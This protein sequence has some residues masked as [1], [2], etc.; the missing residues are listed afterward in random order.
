MKKR[1]RFLINTLG[2]GGA[3]KVLVDLLNKLDPQKYD[4]SLVI[5]YGGVNREKLHDHIHVRQLVPFR[6]GFLKWL[7]GSLLFKLPDK[8]FCACFLRGTYDAEIA[9]LEGIPT[10]RIAALKTNAA[11]IAFVHQDVFVENIVHLPYGS[12]E[13]CLAAYRSLD[14]VCFVSKQAQI[15]FEKSVGELHNARILHNVVDVE[16][17]LKRS[18]EP[19][20]E[21]FTTTGLKLVTVGR[22]ASPK[23]YQRLLR[24]IHRL[25]KEY[26]MELWI[27]GDGEERAVLERMISKLKLS[28]VRLLGY[29]DNPYALVKQAD[30]FVCSSDYEGYSTAVTEAVLLGVPVLTTDCAGMDEILCDGQYGIIVENS[31]EGMFDGLQCLLCDRNRYYEIKKIVHE[32]SQTLTQSAS[33]SAY[34]L[35]FEE[36]C[37]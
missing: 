19:V 22:L 15:G 23:N 10:K 5:I 14:Q 1:L 7:F 11:R 4:L 32:R 13:K 12:K 25:E 21:R 35:L 27:I 2:G 30:L 18:E 34:D 26:P 29:R 36:V 20:A 9:Y 28:S 6:R 24:V 31:D 3:E 17:I 33:T 37:G 8:L 16:T